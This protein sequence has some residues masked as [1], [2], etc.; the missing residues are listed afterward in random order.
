MLEKLKEI[1][2]AGGCFWGIEKYIKNIYGVKSTEVGYAN[3]L[4]KDPTYEDVCYNETGYAETVHIVYD[5]LKISLESLLELYYEVI[6]PTLFNKQGN[7]TGSQ[8]RTGI[9][10]I[11]SA[12][13]K[14]IMESIDKLQLKYD[15]PIVIEVKELI[16]FYKAEEYHQK[17]LDKNPNGYCH[18]N[19]EKLNEKVVDKYTKTKQEKLN[20]LTDI[21]YRVT[22][23]NE[24]ETPFDNPYYNNFEKGIYVDITTGEPLFISV[25]KFDSGCGWPSFSKPI[26][27]NVILIKEDNIFFM[28]RTEVR[29]KISNSHLGH[30]F[31]DGPKETG[32]KRYCINSAALKFIGID[33]MEE[34]GYGY[35]LSYIK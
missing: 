10:Y 18:I 21:Q 27:P 20:K 4:T 1:Y 15:K 12:D 11:D 6:D 23:N 16:I 31:N 19:K 33:K 29:S 13:L 28:K 25:D 9:Y 8:Y 26:D 7:D 30:V 17:Y 22:Q 5:S 35:L 24:T 34:E 14:I 3:G 2:V 32:G